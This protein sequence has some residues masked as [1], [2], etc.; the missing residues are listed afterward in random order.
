MRLWS[1]VFLLLAV[2]C[3]PGD[4]VDPDTEGSVRPPFS[5]RGG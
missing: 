1:G 4:G 2:A 3:T 5:I